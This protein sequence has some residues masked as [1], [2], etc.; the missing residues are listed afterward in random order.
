MVIEKWRI[1]PISGAR[2]EKLRSQVI[3]QMG[4]EHL[5]VLSQLSEMT[6]DATLSNIWLKVFSGLR[7]DIRPRQS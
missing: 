7:L 6:V 1:Q 2:G 5:A 3:Q 4:A